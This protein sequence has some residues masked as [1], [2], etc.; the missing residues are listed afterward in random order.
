VKR[1]LLLLAASLLAFPGIFVAVKGLWIV[2]RRSS[3]VQGRRVSGAAAV[4]A[5]LVLLAWGAAMVGFAVLV[6][7][8]YARQ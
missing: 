4:G 7:L 6:L 1:A 8:A 3:V 2:R 5:G